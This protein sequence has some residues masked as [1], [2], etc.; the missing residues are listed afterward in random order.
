MIS[1]VV[2]SYNEEENISDCAREIKKALAGEDFEIIYVDDGSHDRTWEIICREADEY[3]RGLRFSRNFGKEA[4][5]R[6][7]L[8]S[9]KGDAVIVIDCDL[10]HPPAV[11]PEMLK[12]WRE[13]AQVVEGKKS[14]RGRE[15]VSHGLSAS[16]FNKMMSHSTG[17]DMS[18]ASDFILLDRAPLTALLSYN[19]SGSFFRALAQCVGFKHEAVYYE[20]AAREKGKGKFTFKILVGYALKNIASF[21][22]AP[23][24]ISAALGSFFVILSAVL[25]IVKLILMPFGIHLQSITPGILLL[26]LVGGLIL[27]CLGIIGFYLSRIYEEVKGRPRYIISEVSNVKENNKKERREG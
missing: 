4:A 22:S 1:V 18:G 16:L 12:K 6:A 10:Q 19:E 17:F 24:Y 27:G 5:I 14:Y 13:G 7:G 20:V 2:P 8:D 26:L 25:L 11:I 21:S 3:V 23:L 15:S 9:A